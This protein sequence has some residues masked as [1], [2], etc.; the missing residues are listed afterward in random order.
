[1]V[2]VKRG[3][4]TLGLVQ[5]Q[6]IIIF[7]RAASLFSPLLSLPEA[8]LREHAQRLGVLT[9]LERALAEAGFG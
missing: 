2:L 7:I 5:S 1:M 6:R 8:Y 4:Y 3:G 9:L